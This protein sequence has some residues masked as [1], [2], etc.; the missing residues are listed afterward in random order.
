[1]NHVQTLHTLTH[2]LPKAYSLQPKAYSLKP[3]ALIQHLI[4]FN[5]GK[6]LNF[7]LF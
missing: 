3:T 5:G 4:Q 7:I 1:M 6:P 2:T